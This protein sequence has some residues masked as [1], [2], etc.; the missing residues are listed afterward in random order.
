MYNSFCYFAFSQQ[1]PDKGEDPPTSDIPD[2]GIVK[3][4]QEGEKE[5]EGEGEKETETEGEGE[6]KKEMEGE[7]EGEKDKEGEK[8]DSEDSGNEESEKK[9]SYDVADG[10]DKEHSEVV[11]MKPEEITCTQK[12]ANRPIYSKKRKTRC[13]CSKLNSCTQYIYAHGV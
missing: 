7:G 12:W 5:K 10:P 13:R 2:G 1:K 4:E 6:G 11:S 8:E 9:G 3:M